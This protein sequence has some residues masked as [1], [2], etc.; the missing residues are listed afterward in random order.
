MPV[1]IKIL[2][3]VCGIILA[4]DISYLTVQAASGGLRPAVEAIA[5]NPDMNGYYENVK[6]DNG[7]IYTGDFVAG[8][9]DGKG[10][11]T[12][13]DGSY[14]E[15][16]WSND[17][18]NGKGIYVS[19]AGWTYAG[20]WKDGLKHGKG[21][22]TYSD[23]SYYDGDWYEDKKEGVGTH[24]Y[25]GENGEYFGIYVGE[26]FNDKRDGEGT[27]TYANGYIQTGMWKEDGYV[28]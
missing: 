1:V 22:L 20:D 5:F 28:K 9:Y 19:A 18:E 8:L 16:E 10:K 25:Y 6:S 21:K 24:T 23:T 26:F 15:G 12:Y 14:Y 7:D 13:S 2:M 3:A 17:K 27:L 11:C 4:G